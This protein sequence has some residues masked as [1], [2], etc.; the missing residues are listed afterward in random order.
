MVI[1]IFIFVISTV[2]IIQ[3]Y[4]ER[5]WVNLISVLATPYLILVTF[6]NLFVYKYGFYKISDQVLWMIMIGIVCFY[7]GT[8]PVK[9][10]YALQSSENENYKL[11][12]KYNIKTM[13]VL[14]YMIAVLG[15]LKVYQMF[16]SGAFDKENFGDA[17]GVIGNGVVG[18]LLNFSY[19]I[20][21]FV[22]L[23]WTYH[24]SKILYLL[25]VLLLILVTFGTFIKYN[26]IGLFVTLF[27]FIMIYR[28]SLLRKAIIVLV[29]ITCI[30]FVSNYAVGF[31][32]SDVEVDSSFYINHLWNYASG[33]LIYD[34]YIFGYHGV[35]VGVSIWYK[36]MTFICGLPNM[37]IY[38]LSG[39]KIFPHERQD[40][41]VISSD[42]TTSNVVDAIGY[43][44]PSHGDFY[45]ILCFCAVIM[46]I[47]FFSA[48]IYKKGMAKS[49]RIHSFLAVYITYF[50]FFSFFGTFYIVSGPWEILVYSLIIP[51][52]FYS[53]NKQI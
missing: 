21:P 1:F 43:I 25:P 20:A 38:K 46:L 23:Y 3:Y 10:S 32:L 42:G 37:F 4:K 47:G 34:N 49:K 52:L 33:S 24:K 14:L 45:E 41:L 9:N 28:K 19:S 27:M 30:V 26:V 12:Q 31:F 48:L 5:R 29:S 22:F 50:V 44:Y 53:K 11:L 13:T 51:Q 35:R 2:I 8:L 15:F 39:D 36:L 6:N 40:D 18:H 17:E 7:V 16:S